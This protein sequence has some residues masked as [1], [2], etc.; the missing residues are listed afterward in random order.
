LHT[1]ATSE[2]KAEN[3]ILYRKHENILIMNNF[4]PLEVEPYE[5]RTG[6]QQTKVLFFTSLGRTKH[7]GT[8][9]MEVMERIS[10]L[11]LYS[12]EAVTQLGI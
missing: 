3:N 12:Q 10:L 5:P 8:E 11:Q 2:T 7:W 1:I 4:L 9:S 6:A